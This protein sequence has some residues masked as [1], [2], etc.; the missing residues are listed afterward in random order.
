M[1]NHPEIAWAYKVFALF[2]LI[3]GFTHLDVT[4]QQRTMGFGALIKAELVGAL[5]SLV[6]LWPLAIGL[7]DYR[8]MLFALLTDQVLRC[9]A[10]HVYATETFKLGWD[11]VIVKRALT[12]GLPLMLAGV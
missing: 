2:P 12:L 11:G 5:A 10:T 7:G 6:L 9:V 8:V 4:R 3:R 1:F